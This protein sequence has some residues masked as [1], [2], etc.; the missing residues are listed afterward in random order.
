MVAPAAP[1][2][3]GK[4]TARPRFVTSGGP[5]GRNSPA[6]APGFA[7]IRR[8]RDAR[9]NLYERYEPVRRP[10]EVFFWIAVMAVLGTIS[11]MVSLIDAR[12]RAVP[13]APWEI[14]TW[15]R[16]ATWCCSR[17]CQRWCGSIGASIRWPAAT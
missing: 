1:V 16:P 15:E 5:Q 2:A 10:V 8:M 14:V 7:R 11:T 9:K 4:G 12:A 3:R 13:H 6:P 17:C